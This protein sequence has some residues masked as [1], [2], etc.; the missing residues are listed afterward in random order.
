V[1]IVL[2]T[3]TRGEYLALT[4]ASSR[5]SLVV[6]ALPAPVVCEVYDGQ[7]VL[8]ASG[9]MASPW[10]TASGATVT[11][12]EVTGQGIDVL[13]GG[14]PDGDWYCQF[15]SGSRFVRGTFGV[16][17]SGRDFVWSL[18]SFTTGSRGTLGTVA[19]SSTGT[20]LP[21]VI[22]A[23]QITGTAQAG[24]TLTLSTGTWSNSPTS[25]ARTWRNGAT[26]IAGNV[27][28]Y[29][30]TTADIGRTIVGDVVA[31]NASGST[32][33]TSNAVGPIVAAG[34]PTGLPLLYASNVTDPARRI[35]AFV[36]PGTINGYTHWRALGF[37]FN[38]A[39][40][41]GA[42]SFFAGVRGGPMAVTEYSNPTPSASTTLSALPVADIIQTPARIDNN[43]LEGIN[44]PPT[45]SSTGLKGLLVHAGRLIVTAAND[46]DAGGNQVKSHWSR[47][48]TLADTSTVYGPVRVEGPVNPG[49]TGDWTTGPFW[50]RWVGGPMCDIP[51]EWQSVM[52]GPCLTMGKPIS[53]DGSYSNG[54][55]CSVFDPTDI[56]GSGV[57]ITDASLLVGYKRYG[58]LLDP[59]P[60]DMGYTV[61][62]ATWAPTSQI[63][64][65][66]WVPGTRSVLFFGSHGT[67]R[68]TYGTP[69]QTDI[70]GQVI[71]DPTSGDQGDHA[72]PYV[73]KVWAY[74]A[75][76]LLAVKNGTRNPSSLDPY[77][78]WEFTTPTGPVPNWLHRV[79]GAAFDPATDR[80]YI[81]LMDQW[82]VDAFEP[83]SIVHVFQVT[84]S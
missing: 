11:V 55:T 18:A 33:A 38:P 16:L 52:G 24:S 66:V 53:I 62:N 29:A 40:G 43:T 72:W 9:T 39:G 41:G 30:L 8:R 13:S 63:G 1:S 35:G 57:T 2:D 83:R 80:L 21:I 10:A 28:T 27:P 45:T 42:G 74:D 37:A 22:T 59:H 14:A 56:T 34:D 70:T 71:V 19:L 73:Y 23:P 68:S 47:P 36:A 82:T 32:L 25:Y 69:G 12:G 20:A 65:I 58:R 77:A 81:K 15:R 46:Y 31:T 48:L 44:S 6:S 79:A 4:T 5:A 76:D 60:E 84:R 3:I 17:G 50:P 54:P 78:T 61:T 67:G 49:W 51:A 64:G 75:N 7:D 26:Q